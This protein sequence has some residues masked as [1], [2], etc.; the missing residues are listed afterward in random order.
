[1]L[2]SIISAL[3]SLS[4]IGIFVVTFLIAYIENLFPPSPSDVLLVFVGTLCGIG[5]VS[6]ETTLIVAT[7]GSISG[8]STAYW[9]GRGYGRDIIKKGWVPFVTE[10]LIERVDTWF[11]RYHGLIIV[12]NRFLAGTRAVISFAAGIS[13][14]PFPRTLLYCLVSAAAW[15]A[16]LIY[17]G[18]QV[19]SRWREVDA[20]LSVYGWVVTGILVIVVAVWLI[21]K[22][23]RRSRE[24]ENQRTREPD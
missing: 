16:L 24:P 10:S 12:A 7:A 4:P 13:R 5:T 22:R 11:A 17:I 2:E 15:N 23:K 14:M 9:I 6:F 21:R 18:M 8:F 20:L 3:S 19:G 1:M